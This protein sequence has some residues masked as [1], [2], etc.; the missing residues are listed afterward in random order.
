MEISDTR[1]NKIVTQ[2]GR[3]P[4]EFD[5]A[6]L[7]DFLGI[8]CEGIDI[9]TSRKA[10]SFDSFSHTDGVRNICRRRDLSDEICLLPFRSQLLPLQIR[11]LHTILQ[12]IVTPRKGYEVGRCPTR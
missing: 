6:D 7:A 3:V 9:Y 2:V 1:P 4:I 5:D 11:I 10:L 8:S 12:H